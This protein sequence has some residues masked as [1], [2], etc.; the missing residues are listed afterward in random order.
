MNKLTLVT[1]LL[2]L[3]LCAGW[4]LGGSGAC[5]DAGLIGDR[6]IVGMNDGQSI[7]VFIDL[8]NAAYPD[9]PVELVDS[10]PNR[11]IHLVGFDFSKIDPASLPDLLSEIE[12]DFY[13]QFDPDIPGPVRFAEGLYVSE[14]P[15][16]GTGSFWLGIPDGSPELTQQYFWDLLD[17]D[18]ALP[19]SQGQ[20]VTV[21]VIDT[22]VDA[23]HP[24][25]Q[26]AVLASVGFNFVQENAITGDIAAQ[27]DS[28]GDGFV[29][30]MTGHGTFVAGLIA[31]VAPE[32]K[33]VPIIAL[34][35][36][37]NGNL[38]VL[39]KSIFHAIDQGVDIV[40]V[41]ISSTYKSE[42]VE[43][44]CDEA[45]TKG[46]VIVAAAG[47]CG[48]DEPEQWPAYDDSTFGVIATDH[49]DV[50]ADFSNFSED[51]FICAPGNTVSIA[52]EPVIMQ[53]IISAMP[54]GGYAAWS[55]TSFAAPLTSGA[56][57]LIRAQFPDAA[58]S[59]ALF[60]LIQTKLQISAVDICEQNSA[61]CPGD[62]DSQLGF[63]RVNIGGA[64]ALS[65]P[66]PPLGDLNFDGSVGAADLADILA[67]WGPC[68]LP[69]DHCMADL[70][71]DN[72]IGPADLAELLAHWSR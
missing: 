16:G 22:G 15:E 71:G 68:P 49:N 40:N 3:T 62:D 11:N 30:E 37:G 18:S 63:G 70:T 24:V 54:D 42:A 72:L 17:M 38:Y 34:D 64:V 21:A 14:A 60:G 52:G 69:P 57:A 45:R 29:D 7:E 67:S 1:Q 39:A 66:A 28:D 23:E 65:P 10:I 51:L 31:T 47:N 46:I 36:N 53:S 13:S 48:V 20:G 8:F 2:S 58:R 32:A 35:S 56:A 61:Y 33:I 26:G 4:A 12:D 41:S 5:A 25:L 44:A 43:E 27:A 55:G 50:K 9:I 19:M 59:S 6:A